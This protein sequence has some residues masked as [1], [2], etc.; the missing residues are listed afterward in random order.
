M[1]LGCVSFRSISCALSTLNLLPL[2]K[3]R[4]HDE[5]KTKQSM[6]V[7]SKMKWSLGFGLERIGLL[8]LSYP[9]IAS[10]IVLLSIVLSIWS[11]PRLGFNGD[12]VNVLS[13]NGQAFQEYQAQASA[14]HDSSKDLAVILEHDDFTSVEVFEGL[15][16]LHLDLSLEDGVQSVYSVFTV[17]D[18]AGFSDSDDALL[19]VSFDNQQQVRDA[20][21]DILDKE[22]ATRSILAPDAGAMMMIVSLDDIDTLNESELGE[23]IENF[24][25]VV[26]E[27]A[28]A[29]T[30]VLLSGMPKIRTSIVAAIVSDQTL[31][32]GSGIILG[33]LVAWFIFGT[34]RSALLCTVPAFLAVLWI[35]GIFSATDIKL[36]FFTTALPTLA[37]IIAFADSIVLYFRWK[38]L[39]GELT[40]DGSAASSL[41]H[42]REAICQVGPASSLTSITT[43]LAFASFTWAQNATMDQFAM[44]GVIS[45]LFAFLGVIV[46]LPLAAYWSV[47]FGDVFSAGKGPRFSNL[48]QSISRIVCAAPKPIAIV[49]VVLVA[50]FSWAHSQLEASYT[51]SEYFPK[52]SEIR[53]SE[54]LA[55]SVFG[56]T[57]QYYAV[58]PVTEG[59]EFNDSV[60]RQRLIDLDAKVAKVFGR[61]KTLSLSTAWQRMSES[62]IDEI[63]MA[64][65]EAPEALS[66]RFVSK[67]RRFMQV[68]VTTS[69]SESTLT[70][71]QPI[72]QLREMVAQLPFSDEVSIT[73]LRVLMSQSFPELIEDLR[74]GLMVS[75]FFA[76]LIIALATR[77]LVLAFAS[78][79]PNLVP[80]L[81]AESVMWLSGAS[82]SVTNVIA[83][84]IAFGISIDNAVHV[85]NAYQSRASKLED[86]EFR[87]RSA[88]SEIAPAL[89][90]S[91]C[92]VCVAA[93][94]TQFSSM[95]TVTELGL[96][97]IA[98]L[99]VA[100]IS[101]LAILPS[102]MIL[103]LRFSSRIGLPK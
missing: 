56:G 21:E 38:A 71:N 93:I 52:N 70:V 12:V 3:S 103:M 74:M 8:T 96:L 34:V 84:T 68:A 66:G 32:T 101:N 16:D 81:F 73:G 9:R 24:S 100:L 60:N 26:A 25:Q 85:I 67:D 41:N 15:R 58:L 10:I 78:L 91:T 83:L 86:L 50:S 14:F 69:S 87:V 44:F 65:D 88:V 22:P 27:L 47:R 45:V 55:D 19:P 92:I 46:G 20:L 57:A 4:T 97:L 76:V 59:G 64:L 7:E 29:G 39:R 33:C 13:S 5:S 30:R 99:L 72:K 102:M 2:N 53:E 35:L 6:H 43:A 40:G 18:A 54:Q 63:P 48:G 1:I 31:L 51:L 61:D 37:L 42:L 49:S 79:I 23:R 28:P 95:P 80:I 62:Q 11:L 90:A 77:N 89:L 94:I 98:T 82:L 75:I 17:G 36:S